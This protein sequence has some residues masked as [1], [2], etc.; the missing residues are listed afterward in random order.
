MDLKNVLSC[1]WENLFQNTKKP[2]LY[3]DGWRLQE[4]TN[5]MTGQIS[6][7]EI[8]EGEQGMSQKQH[9]KYL[10]HIISSDG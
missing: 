4:V 7:K 3:V 1:M 5:T 10:G 6:V 9:D 2:E 8:F